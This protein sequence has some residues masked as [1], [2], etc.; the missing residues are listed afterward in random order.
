MYNSIPQGDS[1]SGCNNGVVTCYHRMKLLPCGIVNDGSAS[2]LWLRLSARQ[3][4][5][6]SPHAINDQSENRMHPS[7][8]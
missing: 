1:Q 6:H 4:L 3:A 7:L 2:A 5:A 8:P